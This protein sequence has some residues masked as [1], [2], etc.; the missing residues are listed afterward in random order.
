MKT[1]TRIAWRSLE[2][3]IRHEANWLSSGLH[4]IEVET[5]P[6]TPAPITETGY[7]SEFVSDEIFATYEDA[8]EY[9]LLWLEAAAK[10][11]DGQLS[12]F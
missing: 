10:D 5:E 7:R 12:L 3:E 8:E 1:S 11:W 9:V 2:L 6:R 4:H